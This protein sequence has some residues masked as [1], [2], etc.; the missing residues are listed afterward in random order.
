MAS[1]N[2]DYL[3][4]ADL[5]NSGSIE[6]KMLEMYKKGSKPDKYDMGY[7]YSTTDVRE[8]IINWYPFKKDCTILE[9]GG[10][11]GAITGALLK[12]SKKVVS[13][14]YS[15]RRA[16]NIYYR[17]KDS[18]NLEVIVG[19]LN[20]VK[21]KEKFDY[22]VL[23][24][25]FEYAKRFSDS[26]NPFV[27]FLNN[28]KKLLKPSGIILIAIE[29]RY[30]IK[31][32]AGSMEDHYPE[33]YLGIIGYEDKDIQTL[34]KQEL[35]DIFKESGIKYSK[36]YYPFPDYKMPYVVYTDERLPLHTELSTLLYYN[37]GL[38]TYNYDYRVALDGLL[39]NN[40]FGFFSNS[41]LVEI[42][43]DRTSF[44]DVVFAKTS[45]YRSEPYQIYTIQNSKNE[46]Y[47]YPKY[48][49]G[50]VHLQELAENQINLG[51]LGLKTSL[52][53][54]KNNRFYSK[55]V[56][57]ICL[58]EYIYQLTLKKDKKGIL[59]EIDNYKKILDSISYFGNI[60]KFINEDEEKYFNKRKVNILKLGLIDLHFSNI[61]KCK[62]E[63][64]IIDQEWVSKYDI[65]QKYMLY[66]SINYLFEWVKRFDLL[67]TKEELFK[68][69]NISNDEID[70]YLKMSIDI[71]VKEMKNIDEKLVQIFGAEQT[72]RTI[73]DQDEVI[74]GLQSKLDNCDVSVNLEM[75]KNMYLNQELESITLDL[76][77]TRNELEQMKSNLLQKDKELNEKNDVI[78]NQEKECERLLAEKELIVS[79]YNEIVNSKRFKFANRVCSVRDKFVKGGRNNV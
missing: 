55:Y 4:D 24:G 52:I 6:E 47:K 43:N 14:E 1:I 15:K 56:N 8:N 35:L 21:F 50:K 20:K 79:N 63:Y 40:M 78:L 62:N 70:V 39:T 30:G 38:Q 7:F 3:E 27:Y 51:K 12:K 10:G 29:N 58:C 67:F 45:W 76:N 72:F 19:N 16:E 2:Y 59:Q 60:S 65:P 22:I 5:Y 9:V 25:V 41:F 44:S 37:H 28:L 18:K 73:V 49:S 36:F 33:K 46:I 32:W 53:Y 13:C 66:F 61:I 75:E 11:L 26:N 48:D 34:G 54:R 69:Y 17:H 77:N 64:V 42:G 74:K 23:I 71:A 57:G 31:Y 68:R